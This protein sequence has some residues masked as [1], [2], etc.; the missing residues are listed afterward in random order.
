MEKREEKKIRLVHMITSLERG[1]AQTVLYELLE[2][3]DKTR[4]E[5]VVIYFI[6]GV[7]VQKIEALGIKTY[8]VRGFLCA[9][10]PLFFVRLIRLI[11]VMQQDK[12]IDCLHTVLWSANFIGRIFASYYHL[13]HIESLHNM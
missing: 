11:K 9:Y 10:D 6:P 13:V 7:Y 4:F 3:L 5:Q 12:T 2:G 1:G 8:H